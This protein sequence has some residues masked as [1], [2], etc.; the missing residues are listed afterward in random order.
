MADSQAGERAGLQKI[1]DSARVQKARE[2]KF[3]LNR[4]SKHLLTGVTMWRLQRSA[5][6]GRPRLSLL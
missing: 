2:R 3:W 6:C 4:R 1:R 5:R